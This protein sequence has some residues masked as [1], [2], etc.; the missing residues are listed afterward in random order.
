MLFEYIQTQPVLRLSDIVAKIRHQT[1]TT[2]GNEVSNLPV[3]D[4]KSVEN[5]LTCVPLQEQSG[6]TLCSE[7][8][9]SNERCNGKNH[10]RQEKDENVIRLHYNKILI[11]EEDTNTLSDYFQGISQENEVNINEAENFI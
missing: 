5:T 3:E 2:S 1:S 7:N 4:Q 6:N 8:V 9:K 11:K 10:K